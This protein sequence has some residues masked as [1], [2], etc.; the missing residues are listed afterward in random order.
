MSFYILFRPDE[1]IPIEKITE[2]FNERLNRFANLVN[3]G[4]V[5]VY[6]KY[7]NFCP[8]F[9][10]DLKTDLE[11]I[12][13]TVQRVDNDELMRVYEYLSKKMYWS[14]LKLYYYEY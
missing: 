10:T 12:V 1:I 13:L 9:K 2:Y 4:K 5:Q 7:D 14:C 8:K 3:E 6:K 11:K